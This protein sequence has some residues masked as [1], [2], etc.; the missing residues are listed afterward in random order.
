MK[1]ERESEREKG[2]ERGG[3]DEG[4]GGEGELLL[5]NY[6]DWAGFRICSLHK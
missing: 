3:G 4:G 6:S 1:R 5:P 2:R